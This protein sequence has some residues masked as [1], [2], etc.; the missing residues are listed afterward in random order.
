MDETVAQEQQIFHC[1]S[2]RSK[3]KRNLGVLKS[4]NVTKVLKA[5]K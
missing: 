3:K 2:L 4:A 1:S 5:I